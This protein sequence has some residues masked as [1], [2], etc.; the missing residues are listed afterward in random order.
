MATWSDAT[1]TTSTAT[2]TWTTGTTAGS[3]WAMYEP[4]PPP[5]RMPATVKRNPF[6]KKDFWDGV[7][8]KEYTS[9]VPRRSITGKIIIGKMYRRTKAVR[10]IEGAAYKYKQF[11]KTKELF[12]EKLRGKA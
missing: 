6:V 4:A 3:A 5:P 9:Y 10:K 7:D 11:A 2:M 1:G 12:E 8:W